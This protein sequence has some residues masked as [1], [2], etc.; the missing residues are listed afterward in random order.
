MPKSKVIPKP[1]E[2]PETPFLGTI[3]TLTKLIKLL[4]MPLME[5]LLIKKAIKGVTKF[6]LVKIAAFILKKVG[7]II[8]IIC[9]VQSFE[10]FTKNGIG[11]HI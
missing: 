5:L 7:L 3:E 8:V 11:K 6:A 9:L 10:N 2:P 4:T 1:L